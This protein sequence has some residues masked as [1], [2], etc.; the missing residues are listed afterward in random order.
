MPI[1]HAR[2]EC[3][4]GWPSVRSSAWESAPMTSDSWYDAVASAVTFTEEASARGSVP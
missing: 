2:C 1:M 3:P 4:T